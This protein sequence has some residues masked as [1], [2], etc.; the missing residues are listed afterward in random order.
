MET[1]TARI[2]RLHAETKKT[3][4][5]AAELEAIMAKRRAE[6]VRPEWIRVGP[7]FG[8]ENPYSIDADF[9]VVK[10]RAYCLLED[11]AALVAA[12]N[13]QGID[14]HEGRRSFM[15]ACRL[16]GLSWS[17]VE[18]AIA[19]VVNFGVADAA[20]AW[21]RYLGPSDKKIVGKVYVAVAGARPGIVKIGFSKNPTARAKSLTRQHSTP[22][23]II[24]DEN[25]TM[26]HEW[27]I[28]QL[29][30]RASVSPEWYRAA[31]IPS[32]LFPVELGA[33]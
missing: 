4:K 17:H 2:K 6:F 13:L 18:K 20:D 33:A 29:L 32:W 27:A 14:D 31:E 21:A 8:K 9:G 3:L 23:D 12:A 26:L 30:H 24:H 28:H 5:F 1:L 11:C 16:L 7:Q 25:G 22:I 15:L 10:M 19:D